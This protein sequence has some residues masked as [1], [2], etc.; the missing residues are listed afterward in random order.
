VTSKAVSKLHATT[1]T[2]HGTSASR[3]LRRK[4]NRVPAILYGGNEP[5]L[6][7]SLDHNTIVHAL[8]DPSFYSRPLPFTID[9]QTQQYDVVVKGIQRHHT[10]NSEVLHLDFLRVHPTDVITMRVPFHFMGGAKCPGCEKGGIVNHVMSDLE[11]RCPA[12]YLPT[13]IEVDISRLELNQTLHISHLTLPKGVE[14]VALSHGPEHDHPVV[15]IHLPRSA[16]MEQETTTS[17]DAGT[18]DSASTN[19]NH[20]EKKDTGKSKSAPK[21]KDAKGK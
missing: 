16:S 17:S 10:K 12:Q 5:P 19:A 6:S 14:S 8:K 7:I 15:S 21:S 4:E 2:E 20:S 18:P 3:R 9:D 1:R 13:F 11:V